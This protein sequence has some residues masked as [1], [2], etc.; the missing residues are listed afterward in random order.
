MFLSPGRCERKPGNT[1]VRDGGRGGGG[2]DPFYHVH[3]SGGAY[4]VLAQTA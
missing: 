1:F 2:V 4:F 3:A